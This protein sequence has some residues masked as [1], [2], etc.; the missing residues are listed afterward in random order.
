MPELPEVERLRRSLEPHLLNRFI[1]GVWV[2]RKD[3][4]TGIPLGFDLLHHATIDRLERRGKQLAIIA[5]DTRAIVVHLGMSGQLFTQPGA[6]PPD[7]TP[8]TG[9]THVHLAWQVEDPATGTL[10]RLLFRDPRRFGGVW[11]F[12]NAALIAR[13]L[14]KPLGPDA[15]DTTPDHLARAARGSRRAVK[16]LLLDQAVLAGVGNIYA[17]ESLHRANIDPRRR[18]GT[19]RPHEWATLASAI[20]TTLHAAINAGGSTLRDYR[21]ADNLPGG[22]TQS[23]AVYGRA[24]LP[25]PRCSAPLAHTTIAQRTT[26]WCRACQP[27]SGP[28]P[29]SNPAPLTASRSPRRA[30]TP[31]A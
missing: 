30:H 9:T 18:A 25:C 7:T 10:E 29:A 11:T 28:K 12:R 19:L 24:G 26:T 15:L 20:V 1:R 27:R 4:I 17:D 8:E 3:V 2:F 23:H 16:A 6:G 21:D 31:P 22:Y 14:W 5:T 13:D